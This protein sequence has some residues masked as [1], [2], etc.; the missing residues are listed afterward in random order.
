MPLKGN[1]HVGGRAVTV[2]GHNEVGFTGSSGLPL[3]RILTMKQD[4][5]VGIL[6]KAARF[7]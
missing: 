1:N 4:D 6:L 3:V 5:N 7:T 2:L